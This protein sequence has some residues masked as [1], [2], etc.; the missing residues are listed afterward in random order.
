MSCCSTWTARWMNAKIVTHRPVPNVGRRRQVLIKKGKRVR[1]TGT[2]DS[3]VAPQGPTH[4]SSTQG[5]EA[6]SSVIVSRGRHL[7]ITQ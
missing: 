6:D 3:N 5:G 7:E 2:G 1:L 4:V